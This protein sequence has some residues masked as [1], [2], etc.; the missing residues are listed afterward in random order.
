[1]IKTGN[2]KAINIIEDVVT[3]K[4]DNSPQS[5]PLQNPD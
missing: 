5:K 1:M 3:L 2:K 4:G